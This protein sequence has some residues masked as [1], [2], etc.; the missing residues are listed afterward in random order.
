MNIS[1]REAIPLM[2]S[3]FCRPDTLLTYYDAQRTS[4]SDHEEKY[5][6]HDLLVRSLS[7]LFPWV[8]T[9]GDGHFPS[10]FLYVK[11]RRIGTVRF[12]PSEGRVGRFPKRVL[13]R[14]SNGTAVSAELAH[15]PSQKSASLSIF[16]GTALD[17][18]I[19]LQYTQTGLNVAFQYLPDSE[20]NIKYSVGL[21]SES[22]LRA[23]DPFPVTIEFF[24]KSL[25]GS[26]TRGPEM[27]RILQEVNQLI[28]SR[29][30]KEARLSLDDDC[31]DEFWREAH[32]LCC[33]KLVTLQ[34]AGVITAKD[35]EDAGCE[36][37]YSVDTGMLCGAAGALGDFWGPVGTG[38][39]LLIN[40]LIM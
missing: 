7:R 5:R 40:A 18:R 37:A 26:L 17:A 11:D 4:R 29:P 35:V 1:R 27:P 6:P 38:A 9:I 14:G 12:Q 16:R 15:Q 2:G 19:S 21:V 33:F 20:M 30:S 24:G 10:R 23:G 3:A 31:T 34:L 36:P 25:T 13:G 22:R 39:T 32:M 8:K 28:N